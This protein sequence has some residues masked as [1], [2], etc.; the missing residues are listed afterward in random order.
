MC[1]NIKLCNKEVCFAGSALKF[2]H[3]H[4]IKFRYIHI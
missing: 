1:N 3:L 2:L 4:L